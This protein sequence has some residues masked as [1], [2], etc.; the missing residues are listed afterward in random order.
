M[1]AATAVFEVNL[2][3]AAP[4]YH[5]LRAAS[6][7]ATA[8][9]RPRAPQRDAQVCWVRARGIAPHSLSST[10][11]NGEKQDQRNRRKGGQSG[12]HQEK[13][14][15]RRGA[16]KVH[17]HA[18]HSG[19]QSLLLSHLQSVLKLR[20][21]NIKTHPQGNVTPNKKQH[22]F[23]NTFRLKCSFCKKT[24]KVVAASGPSDPSPS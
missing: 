16:A 11:N 13:G 20:K 17:G 10:R 14:N 23:G 9:P 8:S 24:I 3:V 18:L 21:T 5:L 2:S 7:A 6:R 15:E 22:T 1:L 12:V 19:R 4:H